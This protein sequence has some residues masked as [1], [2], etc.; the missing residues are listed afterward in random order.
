MQQ[1][2]K[3]NK[4]LER[5]SSSKFKDM[6]S[7]LFGQ[8]K[9]ALK[10]LKIEIKAYIEN[11]EVLS[12][13]KKLE[14]EQQIKTANRIDEILWNLNDKVNPKINEHVAEEAKQGYY[15]TWYAL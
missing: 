13:S 9:E 5:L 15:G 3:W 6:D 12:F 11:Y 14:V 1:L 10:Q 4:E 8:Y 7:E 2:D